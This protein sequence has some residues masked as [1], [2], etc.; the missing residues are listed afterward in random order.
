LDKK[1]I[2]VLGYRKIYHKKFYKLGAKIT[3]IM[4]NS[5]YKKIIQQKDVQKDIE[6]YDRLIIMSDLST[7]KEWSAVI[8]CIDKIDCIHKVVSNEKLFDYY[9]EIV[10][11]IGKGAYDIDVMAATT[12]KSRT[13]DIANRLNFGK[14]K[15]RIIKSISQIKTDS[16]YIGFPCILKPVDGVGS[17]NIFKIKSRKDFEK[18]LPLLANNKQWILEEFIEGKEYSVES[19][20]ENGN[21]YILGIT[22]KYKNQ[23]TFVEI[24]HCFPTQDIDIEMQKKIELFICELLNLIGISEGL[25]H[26]EIIIREDEIFLVETHT[27]AGGD[28]IPELI[29]QASD[30]DIIEIRCRQLLG[31]KIGKYVFDKRDYK[32]IAIWFLCA[33]FNGVVNEVIDNIEMSNNSIIFKEISVRKGDTVRVPKKSSDRLGK[34]IVS[35][36]TQDIA[37][38]KASD[39]IKMITIK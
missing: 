23:E 25:M 37:V 20:S 13:R 1:H 35:G 29:Y 16:Q 36:K 7:P 31:E 26:T 34:I 4:K 22:K 32:H 3:C 11:K 39:L 30:I 6:I 21:H 33:N 9:K 14:V 2:C 8:S 24:G 17:I 10:K 19:I 28:S 15:F 27:R 12:I 5:V 38:N 18:T